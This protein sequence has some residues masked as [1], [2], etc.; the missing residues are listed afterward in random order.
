M[1]VPD[2]RGQILV[3]DTNFIVAGVRSDAAVDFSTDALFTKD[4]VA[5][6]VT[7]R[8]DWGWAD[9]NAAALTT[10]TP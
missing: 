10:V 5:A 3:A 7:M 8:V 9:V 1:A 4:A 2:C 6:R